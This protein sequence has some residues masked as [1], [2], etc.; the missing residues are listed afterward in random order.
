MIT[1]LRV[2]RGGSFFSLGL[3][4]CTLCRSVVQ[5]TFSC[6]DGGVRVVRERKP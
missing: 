2:V 3:R 4:A 5:R 6:D 1:H